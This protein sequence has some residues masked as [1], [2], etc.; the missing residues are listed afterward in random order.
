[1]VT[2]ENASGKK[3]M[4]VVD[5]RWFNEDGELRKTRPEKDRKAPEAGER[6]PPSGGQQDTAAVPPAAGE[7]ATPPAQEPPAGG[8]DQQPP[9]RVRRPSGAEFSVIVDLLAQQAAVFLTGAQGIEKNAAQ[10]RF[11]I[12]LLDILQE[13]TSGRLAPEEA[14]YLRDILAKLQL[15]F[16]E[17][18]S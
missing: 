5:R 6:T 14:A 12:D 3:K 8:R 9:T 7:G 16:V 1:M 11:F 2:G 18:G 13:K 10:A 15:A 4:K 17:S